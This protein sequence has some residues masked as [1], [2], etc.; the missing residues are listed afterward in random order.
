M[1]NSIIAKSNDGIR[2]RISSTVEMLFKDDMELYG[3]GMFLNRLRV[4]PSFYIFPLHNAFCIAMGE[5][6][7]IYTKMPHGATIA[8]YFNQPTIQL[9]LNKIA[10][11]EFA[12]G[13]KLPSSDDT[14]DCRC[15]LNVQD[16]GPNKLNVYDAN[17][18]RI[19]PI[20]LLMRDDHVTIHYV[21]LPTVEEKKNV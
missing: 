12:E 15:L 13:W 18:N 19:S 17:N 8:T 1:K 2:V 20:V 6:L 4:T 5:G 21:S 16:S 14:L 7:R 9:L 3:F 10:E 11:V